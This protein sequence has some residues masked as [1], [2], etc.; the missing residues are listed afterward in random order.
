MLRRFSLYL[1]LCVSFIHGM[2][3]SAYSFS[4]FGTQINLVNNTKSLK[5]TDLIFT[6]AR[7][8]F[9]DKRHGPLYS[10]P[11]FWEEDVGSF[12]DFSINSPIPIIG[13]IE[14]YIKTVKIKKHPIDIYMDSHYWK[15]PD[16]KL[17]YTVSRNGRNITFTNEKAFN[18]ASS[19][20][21]LCY[22]KA[23][24][25]GL[26]RLK[27]KKDKSITFTTP[28]TN[29]GFP[30]KK[31]TLIAINTV[32]D[33]IRNN[34]DSYHKIIFCVR[35]TEDDKYNEYAAL[36]HSLLEESYALQLHKIYLFYEAHKRQQNVLFFL[37]DEII[38]TIAKLLYQ[39]FYP[40]EL[41][42]IKFKL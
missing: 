9:I 12:G 3:E 18:E 32:L 29:L 6:G 16:E 33:F 22:D 7:E 21:V 8:E 41:K 34:P 23:L 24:A 20:L 28:A 40:L 1:I 31:A 10:I 38:H 13:I 2:E 39:T 14:P 36:Y 17:E 30:A 15:T 37:P 5:Q 11:R 42:D 27:N 19:D 26:E 4:T 25:I 35:P